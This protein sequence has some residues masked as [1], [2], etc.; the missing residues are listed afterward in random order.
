ML[1]ARF[2]AAEV[3]VV[4]EIHQDIGALSGEL[5]DKVREGG[6]VA[7]E[8]AEAVAAGSQHFDFAARDKVACFLRH[9][10]DEAKHG[11]DIFAE[12]N[13]FD[14]VITTSFL[15]FRSK[16]DGGVQRLLR[17]SK[18]HGAEQK[19]AMTARHFSG[20]LMEL[21]IVVEIERRGE[22]GPDDQR[23]SKGIGKRGQ[24]L[25]GPFAHRAG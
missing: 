13:E 17:T 5:T 23:R 16:Q 6:L 3:S 19:V 2:A 25:L 9:T 10:V 18:R 14:L 21:W 4:R 8:D 1:L 15:T 20:D 11:R 7:D 12:R 24:L 22:L